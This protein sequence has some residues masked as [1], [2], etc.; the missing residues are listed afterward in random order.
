MTKL[1]EDECLIKTYGNNT[2]IP[3]MNN[4]IKNRDDILDLDDKILALNSV[5]SLTTFKQII[6]R[7]TSI[8]KYELNITE[9]Y[10]IFFQYL[11]PSKFANP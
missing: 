9:E 8:K 4:I 1:Q 2:I 10:I 3:S 6:Y 11:P 5:I 7:Y